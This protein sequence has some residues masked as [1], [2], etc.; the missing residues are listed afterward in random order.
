MSKHY[1]KESRYISVITVRVS[2]TRAALDMMRYDSCWPATEEDSRK[3]E[4]LIDAP[5][6]R[7]GLD[8]PDFNI[9]N[10]IRAGRNDSGATDGR[11]ASFGCEVISV[12][13]PVGV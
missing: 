12:K 7:E 11:W 4:Q 1:K 8:G 10:F 3:L 6:G 13:A 5:R 9:V 2:S